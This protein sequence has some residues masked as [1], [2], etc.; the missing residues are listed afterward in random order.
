VLSGVTVAEHGIVGAM[1][2]A[3]KNVESYHVVAG[4]PAKTVKVKSI[5]PPGVK[6][7]QES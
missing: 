5:A 7:G 1:G 4:I 2:V 6:P 3:S